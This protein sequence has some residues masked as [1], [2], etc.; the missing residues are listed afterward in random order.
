MVTAMAKTG[1]GPAVQKAIR[2]KLSVRNAHLVEANLRTL[3]RG[4]RE[5]RYGHLVRAAAGSGHWAR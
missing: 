3:D 5:L 4:Y 2:Q 1:P